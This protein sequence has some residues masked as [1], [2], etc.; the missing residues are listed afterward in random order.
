[1][2]QAE[3]EK[4]LLTGLEKGAFQLGSSPG[5]VAA[6][7][8]W[9]IYGGATSALRLPIPDS[10]SEQAAA[11][12]DSFVEDVYGLLLPLLIP[13]ATPASVAAAHHG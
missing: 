10:D 11:H 5:L 3:V 9:A 8:S 6:T 4:V 2:V 7:L 12:A 13:G 1:V